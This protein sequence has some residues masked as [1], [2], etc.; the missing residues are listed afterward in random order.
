MGWLIEVMKL[1]QYACIY[2][3][4]HG[5]LC[6]WKITFLFTLWQ[7]IQIYTA[8]KKKKNAQIPKKQC[9]ITYNVV[10][11]IQVLRYNATISRT[12]PLVVRVPRNIGSVSSTLVREVNNYRSHGS[13]FKPKVTRHISVKLC[14]NIS[15]I[16]NVWC[17]SSM[18]N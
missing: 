14:L 10:R 12:V 16:Y 13:R 5:N 7:H 4:F 17:N 1:S 18:Q 15:D 6:F 8:K 3:P 9:L 11:C 2:Y